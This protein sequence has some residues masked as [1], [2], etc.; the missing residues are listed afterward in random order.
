VPKQVTMHWTE[1]RALMAKETKRSKYRNVRVSGTPDG[2]FDS[3]HEYRVWL[4][5]KQDQSEGKIKA[6]ERQVALPLRADGGELVGH[7][8]ADFAFLE[9]EP[10]FEGW[11]A[12]TADAKGH[13][14]KEYIW[15]K[16]HVKAQ[17]GVIIREM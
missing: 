5:L 16:K 6:L 2:D 8:V 10:V 13:R 9:Y 12:V 7:Y 3:G 14:T 4:G 15:K 1:F 11:E 17:Y